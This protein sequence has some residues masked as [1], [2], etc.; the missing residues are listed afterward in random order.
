MELV[1]HFG[2]R[3]E[4]PQKSLEYTSRPITHTDRN[5]LIKFVQTVTIKAAVYTLSR[6]ALQDLSAP[7]SLRA[8]LTA[9]VADSL[10]G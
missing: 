7:C 9:D 5:L 8:N 2:E 4:P 3:V 6:F 1:N 10:F